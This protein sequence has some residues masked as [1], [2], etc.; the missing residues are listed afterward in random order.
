MSWRDLCPW[1]MRLLPETL[2]RDWAKKCNVL[3]EKLAARLVLIIASHMQPR[4]DSWIT[5]PV[6][7]VV[8]NIL[9]CVCMCVCV[10]VCS[11]G[12]LFSI[13][14]GKLHS[15]DFSIT[16]PNV[17]P[18][19]TTPMHFQAEPLDAGIGFQIES[20]TSKQRLSKISSVTASAN[21]P[22]VDCNSEIRCWL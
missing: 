15:I 10:C 11:Q 9:C 22:D 6:F 8:M 2:I 14:Y 4:C 16:H 19:S 7:L 3:V 13:H 21:Y 17:C 12:L 18:L 5:R 1:R 20:P